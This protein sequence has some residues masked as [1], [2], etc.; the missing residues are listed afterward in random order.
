M[1]SFYFLILHHYMGLTQFLRFLQA[2]LRNAMQ[3]ANDL[4]IG[5]HISTYIDMSC[6]LTGGFAE[7]KPTAAEQ[8][9]AMLG[10]MRRL[11]HTACFTAH[12]YLRPAVRLSGLLS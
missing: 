8:R 2:E 9:S 5:T 3:K 7:K 12:L 10:A 1:C 4:G 6:W 11:R